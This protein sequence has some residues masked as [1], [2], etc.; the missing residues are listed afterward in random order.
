[1]APMS[2][3][4]ICGACSKR[5]T[6]NSGGVMCEGKC[7]IWFHFA[8]A[9]KG[10]KD[11]SFSKGEKSNFVCD[12][13]RQETEQRE[14]AV[15]VSH[16]NTSNKE[17]DNDS[18][19]SCD[20][21]FHIKILTDQIFDL[22]KNQR[23]LREQLNLVQAE[24]TRLAMVLNSHTDTIGD[25][26]INGRDVVTYSKVVKSAPQN[27]NST[28]STIN[29]YKNKDIIIPKGNDDK[30]VL[31][32]AVPNSQISA[33]LSRSTSALPS[34]SSIVKQSSKQIKMTTVKLTGT[35]QGNNTNE[36]G[37]HENKLVP[38]AAQGNSMISVPV[39]N[40]LAP[41][42]RQS[43]DLMEVCEV[44]DEVNSDF[45]EVKYKKRKS[46]QR[47][48]T[49]NRH[50][51]LTGR[52]TIRNDKLKAVEKLR[53]IF[54][55]RFSENVT[56]DDINEYIVDS[57]KVNCEITKLKSKHPGYSSFKIGVPTS[58]WSTVFS[59]DFWPE[60]VYISRFRYPHKGLSEA[61]KVSFLEPVQ[62]QSTKT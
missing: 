16:A 12:K 1:M 53:H 2:R 25:I 31:T 23:E 10:M 60:G 48:D 37:L 3:R 62:E 22:T 18:N 54:V 33:G 19:S 14:K 47:I 55:S 35:G 39:S 11:Y 50:K 27:T 41:A 30:F 5:V 9:G 34:N 43:L 26:L 57:S 32:S 21:N 7:M 56:C 38:N 20:C 42:S 24:N 44:D 52:A 29:A 15:S 49:V 28:H 17:E 8:C 6:N 45:V 46:S 36:V 51:F 4:P 58:M 13:C 61:S 40:T 59:E